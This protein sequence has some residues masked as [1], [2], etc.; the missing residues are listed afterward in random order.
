MASTV[1]W[2]AVH[3]GG[4]TGNKDEG[5]NG[6]ETTTLCYCH[7]AEHIQKLAVGS[8]K[9]NH[10]RVSAGTGRRAPPTVLIQYPWLIYF[11]NNSMY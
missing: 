8:T 6:N 10:N 7:F 11:V 2:E 1:G 3:V 9:H 5:L 4:K